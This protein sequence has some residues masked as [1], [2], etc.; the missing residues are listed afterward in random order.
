MERSET[1][2]ACNMFYP[3]S[4]EPEDLTVGRPSIVCIVSSILLALGDSVRSP[5]YRGSGCDRVYRE[6]LRRV[7]IRKR[8]N[9]SVIF[10]IIVGVT[11]GVSAVTVLD[12]T[13]VLMQFSSREEY[14][15]NE[16]HF[17]MF[18]NRILLPNS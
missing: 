3:W 18:F 2:S 4:R 13:D 14:F 5:R 11:A 12:R 8:S 15:E 1:D 17:R 7:S 6:L 10:S 9:R 16:M